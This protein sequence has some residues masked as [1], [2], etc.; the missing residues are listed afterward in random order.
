[1]Y[2]PGG[3]VNDGGNCVCVGVRDVWEIFVISNFAVNL[4][5]FSKKGCLFCFVFKL[6]VHRVNASSSMN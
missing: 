1:M 4:K 2:H 6:T 3:D 5:L